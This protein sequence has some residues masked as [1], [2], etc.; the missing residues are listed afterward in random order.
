MPSFSRS[1]SSRRSSAT[2]SAPP[3]TATPMRAPGRRC[4][5]CNEAAK[6]AAGSAA[7]LPGDFAG[8]AFLAMAACR[9]RSSAGKGG[10]DRKRER[11]LQFAGQVEEEQ[12]GELQV[13]HEVERH[14]VDGDAQ[15][16]ALVPTAADVGPEGLQISARVNAVGNDQGTPLRPE[17]LHL[18]GNMQ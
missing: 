5:E 8:N 2:E 4:G 7:P 12:Q 1:S 9:Y 15:E 13:T 6:W 18:G 11:G 3:E 16:A 17:E 10:R 14:L